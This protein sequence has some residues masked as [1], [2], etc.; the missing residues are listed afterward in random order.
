MHVQATHP[1]GKPANLCETCQAG[2]REAFDGV[3]LP[4]EWL[5]R[6][7]TDAEKEEV[8]V[9]AQSLA[10]DDFQGAQFR[11][12]PVGQ[13]ALSS[14]ITFF[15]V[16]PVNMRSWST[17]NAYRGFLQGIA[18]TTIALERMFDTWKPDALLVMNGRM[19]VYQTAFQLAR[20]RGIRVLVHERPLTFGT[21][22]VFEN[23]ICTSPFPF[24]E[25]WANWSGVALR[26]D[27]IEQ[28]AEWLR[29]RR[30]GSN[31]VGMFRFAS[32]PVGS[33]SVKDSLSIPDGDRVGV[34]FTTSTDEIAG[35]PDWRGPFASQEEF[36]QEVLNWA[37]ET[38]NLTFI[39]RAHPALSG[40]VAIGRANE[41]ISWFLDLQQRVSNKIRVILPDEEVSSYDL[42]EISDFGVTFGSTAGIEMLA[43]GKPI[44]TTPPVPFYD[45]VEGVTLATNTAELRSSLSDA[46][47]SPPNR[48]RQRHA[49]RCIYRFYYSFQ[50]PFP[51]VTMSALGENRRNFHSDEQLK[52]GNDEGLDRICSFLI[53]GVPIF[54]PPS[55]AELTIV[56][57]DE[58]EFLDGIAAKPNWLYA[59]ERGRKSIST[60]KSLRKAL[61]ALTKPLRR[62]LNTVLP[63]E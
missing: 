50:V 3:D 32:D 24:K 40:K 61:R 45:H 57:K 36:I 12:H 8:F 26:K 42:M 38:P 53:D 5:G 9:W 33:K 20:L 18:F 28:A 60:R 30:V 41:Q 1:S 59:A 54:P 21:L 2:A 34:F 58:D 13:W 47:S 56:Q 49:F 7:L 35:E 48:E 31:M 55:S 16:Y 39:V 51:L 6:F 27:E 11:G 17:I 22:R 62:A 43:L 46:M 19:S 44:V 10:P 4:I 29:E 14:V 23:R 52:E 37:E 63:P 15:R 25:F